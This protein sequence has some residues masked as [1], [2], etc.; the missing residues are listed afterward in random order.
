V[1]AAPIVPIPVSPDSISGGDHNQNNHNFI[2]PSLVPIVSP[3]NPLS[4]IIESPVRC[5]DYQDVDYDDSD[6]DDESEYTTF[7]PAGDDDDDDDDNDDF[8]RNAYFDVSNFYNDNMT[9]STADLTPFSSSDTSFY[10]NSSRNNNGRSRSRVFVNRSNNSQDDEQENNQV[11]RFVELRSNLFGDN[12][13]DDEVNH[14]SVSEN[15][16]NDDPNND[17]DDDEEEEEEED[18]YDDDESTVGVLEMDEGDDDNFTVFEN[19]NLIRGFF[20]WMSRLETTNDHDKN[21][22]NH[23]DDDDEEDFGGEWSLAASRLDGLF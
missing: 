6:N 16:N 3:G 1:N 17:H 23:H 4:P 8:I 20:T 22:N 13:R 21:N 10:N 9:L 5:G 14:D 2:L 15:E 19:Q 18:Y 7:S 11:P 12:E